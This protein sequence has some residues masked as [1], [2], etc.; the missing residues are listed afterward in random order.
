[1]ARSGKR[2]SGWQFDETEAPSSLFTR[3]A[4]GR[5]RLE[6]IGVWNVTS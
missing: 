3:T 1:M 6:V 5:C 2:W 4:V